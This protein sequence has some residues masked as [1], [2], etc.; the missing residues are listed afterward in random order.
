MK[1]LDARWRISKIDDQNTK[2]D[3]ELLIVPDWLMPLPHS[4]V[5]GEAA[6]AASRAV[7]GLRNASERR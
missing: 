5:T 4:L 2:L 7:L 6:Y 3:L 1:R